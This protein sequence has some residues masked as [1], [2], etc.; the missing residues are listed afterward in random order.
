MYE[1]TSVF[2]SNAPIH[3]LRLAEMYL[4]RAEARVKAAAVIIF[5]LSQGE[6]SHVTH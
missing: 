4:N 1:C 6:G 3:Y 5:V 2:R